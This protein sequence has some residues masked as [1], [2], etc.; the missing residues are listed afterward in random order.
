[1]TKVLCVSF[2]LIVTYAHK[3]QAYYSYP[4]HFPTPFYAGMFAAGTVAGL[5]PSPPFFQLLFAILFGIVFAA[6]AAE[7]RGS[8]VIIALFVASGIPG[9]GE[10]GWP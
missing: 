3:T 10:S 9:N 4:D 5:P 2:L 1:M 6:L 8:S 7:I